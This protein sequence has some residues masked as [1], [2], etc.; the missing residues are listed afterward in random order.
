MAIILS[1]I[2]DQTQ[3]E[4]QI[5]SQILMLSKANLITILIFRGEM[6]QHEVSLHKESETKNQTK[7][8]S[9]IKMN[10]NSEPFAIAK[11]ASKRMKV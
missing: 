6:Y 9:K 2:R 3:W 8:S 11:Q 4:H 10:N 5:S 7:P 1:S